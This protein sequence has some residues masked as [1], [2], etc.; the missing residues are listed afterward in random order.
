MPLDIYK[1]RTISVMERCRTSQYLVSPGRMF[2]EVKFRKFA[3]PKMG[4]FIFLIAGATESTEWTV[5]LEVA[6][7]LVGTF[8]VRFL[9]LKYTIFTIEMQLGPL[10]SQFGG[11]IWWFWMSNAWL[12][13]HRWVF[14]SRSVAL[15]W[16]VDQLVWISLGKCWFSPGTTFFIY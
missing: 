7:V 2:L 14:W 4:L 9:F 10:M 8:W 13:S 16:N 15:P 12:Y 11:T 6:Q 5:Q 1:A 3:A